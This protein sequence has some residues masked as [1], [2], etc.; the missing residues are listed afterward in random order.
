MKARP[1]VSL[2]SCG[3]GF[4]R[5][6]KPPKSVGAASAAK[7]FQPTEIADGTAISSPLPLAG[8]GLGERALLLLLEPSTPTPQICCLKL[9]FRPYGDSLFSNAKKV[10]KNAVPRHPGLA[11][12]DS[13]HSI[14][15]PRARREGPSLAHRG[16]RLWHP[17]SLYL[18]HPCSRRGIHAAQ[19]STQRF[20]SAF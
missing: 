19:P 14:I 15:A 1:L 7:I 9:R 13:P 2:R 3:R 11:A 16:S 18:L 8:E 4:S 12:L 5:D 10:S 6:P 17:A 20:R